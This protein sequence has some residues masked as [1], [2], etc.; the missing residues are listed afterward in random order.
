MED[1]EDNIVEKVKLEDEYDSLNDNEQDD[2]G[3]KY[4]F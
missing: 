2:D 1:L 4:A 3:T